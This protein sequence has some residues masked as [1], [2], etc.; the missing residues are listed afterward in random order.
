MDGEAT[1]LPWSRGDI[2]GGIHACINCLS[3]WRPELM[4]VGLTVCEVWN[5]FLAVSNV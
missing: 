5:K 3:P 4:W 1:R 2:D